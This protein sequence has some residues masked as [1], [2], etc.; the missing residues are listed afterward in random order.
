MHI[1]RSPSHISQEVWN[2]C[3]I[4]TCIVPRTGKMK[5]SLDLLFNPDVCADEYNEASVFTH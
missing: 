5:M 4:E 2:N 1:C 3:L